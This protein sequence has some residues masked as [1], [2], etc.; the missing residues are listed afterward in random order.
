[1]TADTETPIEAD[2]LAALRDSLREQGAHAPHLTPEQQRNLAS[3]MARM[4]ARRIGGSYIG[5]EAA[6]AAR[7]AAVMRAYYG[8]LSRDEVI[9][10]FIISRRL[11]Y[12]ILARHLS[13]KTAIGK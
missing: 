13:A 9:R 7:D 2:V 11:F 8:G 5:K 1:M 4:L 6:R 12:N 3:T 10:R